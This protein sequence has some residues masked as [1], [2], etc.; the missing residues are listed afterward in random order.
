MRGRNKRHGS[1]SD[2]DGG[3]IVDVTRALEAGH[4]LD[5][6]EE[7][8]R[9]RSEERYGLAVA[10]LALGFVLALLVSIGLVLLAAAWFHWVVPV[11]LGVLLAILLFVLLFFMV[12]MTRPPQQLTSSDDED[13]V[14]GEGPEGD[15]GPE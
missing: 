10:G 11:L 2:A 15:K 4:R 13:E 9:A 7:E 14:Y 12:A 3:V 1:P 5:I 6:L 8:L